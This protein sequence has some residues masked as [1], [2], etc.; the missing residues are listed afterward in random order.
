[1]LSGVHHQL[2][3]RKHTCQILQKRRMRITWIC[4]MHNMDSLSL[5]TAV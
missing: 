1:M 5:L 2:W 3:L 4:S